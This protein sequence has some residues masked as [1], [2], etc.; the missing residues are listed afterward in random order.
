MKQFLYGGEDER[1]KSFYFGFVVARRVVL[2]YYTSNLDFSMLLSTCSGNKRATDTAP[3]DDC[4]VRWDDTF[5]N[6]GYDVS[7]TRLSPE[8]ADGAY[9]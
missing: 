5:G 7:V 9:A 8:T 3:K 2:N 1:R 4:I 6:V